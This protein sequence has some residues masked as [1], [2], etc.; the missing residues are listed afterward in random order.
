M[1]THH[2][3]ADRVPQGR[4]AREPPSRRIAYLQRQEGERAQTRHPPGSP[5]T[6]R[7]ARERGTRGY[8]HLLSAPADRSRAEP[9]GEGAGGTHSASAPS[10]QKSNARRRD[11]RRRAA[12]GGCRATALRAAGPPPTTASRKPVATATQRLCHE[13]GTANAKNSPSSLGHEKKNSSAAKWIARKAVFAAI[14]GGSARKARGAAKKTTEIAA[15]RGSAPIG[16][17]ARGH[18]V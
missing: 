5:S 16:A 7:T 18:G 1:G 4:S 10:P 11:A 15:R 9:A 17:N 14:P 12:T 2:R 8:G 6:A 13:Y 3:P